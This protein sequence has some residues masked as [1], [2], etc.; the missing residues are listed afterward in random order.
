MPK[1]T[2][3]YFAIVDPTGELTVDQVGSFLEKFP[4]QPLHI[5][6]QE[7]TDGQSV[8]FLDHHFIVQWS[9]P[10]FNDFFEEIWRHFFSRGMEFS[11][12]PDG[13]EM[14]VAKVYEQ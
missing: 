9:D 8:I 6:G 10:V 5:A 13:Q 4:G 3:A 12:N 7:V 11:T 14:M 1:G 2:S